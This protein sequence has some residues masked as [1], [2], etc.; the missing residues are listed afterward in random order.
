MAVP[1]TIITWIRFH[2]SIATLASL[3]AAIDATIQCEDDFIPGRVPAVIIPWRIC[4]LDA[5]RDPI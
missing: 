1:D 4:F 2:A 3:G 5:L